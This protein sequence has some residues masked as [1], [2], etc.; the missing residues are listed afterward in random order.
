M[1]EASVLL[2]HSGHWT[3]LFATDPSDGTTITEPT[4]TTTEPL[5]A[6]TNGIIN[7]GKGGAASPAGI[8][9][10][11]YGIGTMTTGKA[12]VYAWNEV[13]ATAIGD[14]SLWVPTKLFECTAIST[15]GGSTQPGVANSPIP[16]TAN[17]TFAYSVTPGTVG[18]AGVDWAVTNVASGG[19]GHVM[20]CTKGAKFLEVKVEDGNGT[21][22]N[23]IWRPC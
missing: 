3:K 14:K 7:L 8:I 11:F 16:A 12:N 1:P 23:G 15:A 5:P 9:L 22:I 10:A 19:I 20:V 17:L 13:R 4:S 21:M 2:V 18:T 6:A